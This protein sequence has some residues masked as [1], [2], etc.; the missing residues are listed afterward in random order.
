MR[1]VVPPCLAVGADKFTGDGRLLTLRHVPWYLHR[2]TVTR[3]NSPLI[4]G[5]IATVIGHQSTAPVLLS[6]SNHRASSLEFPATALAYYKLRP[7]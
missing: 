3:C 6:F 1:F 2:I 7:P 5:E 4:T